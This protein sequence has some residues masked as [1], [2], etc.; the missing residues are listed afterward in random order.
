MVTT[1]V[2]FVAG[3]EETVISE[4]YSLDGDFDKIRASAHIQ[5][6]LTH[7]NSEPSVIIETEEWLHTGHYITVTTRPNNCLYPSFEEYYQLLLIASHFL[8]EC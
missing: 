2:C 8:S 6:E 1:I 7:A 5:F 4:T 3:K